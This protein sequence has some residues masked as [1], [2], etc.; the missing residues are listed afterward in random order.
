MRLKTQQLQALLSGN[1]ISDKMFGEENLSLGLCSLNCPISV[2]C[3]LQ[4][5]KLWDHKQQTSI[6]GFCFFSDLVLA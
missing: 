4:R 2:E 1:N 5:Q 3:P 6:S